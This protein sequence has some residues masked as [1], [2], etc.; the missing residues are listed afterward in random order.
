[1][2]ILKF[3]E[4]QE[5]KSY[6][7]YNPK[8]PNVS[9]CT[10][11]NKVYYNPY[12]V[13]FITAKYIGNNDYG[14]KIFNQEAVINRIW[15][16]GVEIDLNNNQNI[17]LDVDTVTY[18]FGDQ[19]E[20]EIKYL[21]DHSDVIGDEY[22][23][24]SDLTE[25]SIPRY[26]ETIGIS[27]F[28][29]CQYLETVNLNN[30]LINIQDEV[31]SLTNINTI[32]IPATVETIGSEAFS[33]CLNLDEVNLV[34]NSN[35]PEIGEDVFSEHNENLKIIVSE[36]L[37][38]DYKQSWEQYSDIII[39]E[40]QPLIV[41]Y[42]VVNDSH[43]T[44]LYTCLSQ[45]GITVNGATMFDK[46]EL[47]GVELSISDLDT[48]QG[49]Y[50]LSEGEHIVRYTLK[51]PTFI[52]LEIIDM[53]TQQVNIGATFVQCAAISEVNIPNTVTSIGES[54]FGACTGLTNV[55]IP[56]SVTTIGQYAFSNC[57]GLTNITIPNSVTTIGN[58]AFEEC[59]SL[60]N[61]TIGNSVTTI[62]E[63]AFYYCTSLTS[64]TI[65]NGVTTIGAA[66]FADC[67]SLTSV[68]VEAITPPTLVSFDAFENED[69]TTYPIYVPS[70]SVVAYKTAWSSLSS[71]IQAIP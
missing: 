58:G 47:D 38:E 29:D 60:T 22:F 63:S 10:E 25:V 5:Y 51:D 14:V 13:E 50:Q 66:A 21:L 61:I 23:R 24:G 12:K 2:N 7:N 9:Y 33:F 53:S 40:Q 52:G 70:A 16:D 62:D 56:N 42:N 45:E 11:D 48:A 37:L 6:I 4:Y 36:D 68:T 64:V 44:M 17:S 46:I 39:V 27:A 35:I 19:E 31:F 41:K 18:V 59:N 15:I 20:H 34:N 65:G 71:R 43:P 54:A 67:T 55:T 32:T 49:Q 3:S 1:M 30:G 69:T 26:V 57:S 28:R 8:L